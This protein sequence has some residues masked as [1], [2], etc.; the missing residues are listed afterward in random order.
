MAR[1]TNKAFAALSPLRF[2]AGRRVLDVNY[3][4]MLANGNYLY[5]TSGARCPLLVRST[6]FETA[7]ATSTIV[8]SGSAGVDLDRYQNVLR[9]TRPLDL[10]GD[11]YSIEARAL[12]R[13]L[14][15]TVDVYDVLTDASLGTLRCDG[16]GSTDWTVAT[17][18]LELSAAE[19]ETSG[20]P[21]VLLLSIVG[22]RFG[23]VSAATEGGLLAIHAHEVI[24]VSSQL[25]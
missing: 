7:S 10:S 23:T 1:T 15:V 9:C 3:E 2:F 5:S 19:A 4:I 24:A 12:V 21:R 17:D 25:P 8:D 11:K 6:A 20:E 22:A 16:R 14:E 13:D 18:T